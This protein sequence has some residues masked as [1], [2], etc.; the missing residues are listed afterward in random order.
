[1]NRTS[2]SSRFTKPRSGSIHGQDK[3]HWSSGLEVHR[4][5][6]TGGEV[7]HDWIDFMIPSMVYLSRNSMTIFSYH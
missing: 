3:D 7:I 4:Q 6:I 1:M 5:T 2:H